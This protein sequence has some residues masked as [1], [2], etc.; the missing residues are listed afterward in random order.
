MYKPLMPMTGRQPKEQFI[1]TTPMRIGALEFGVMS[2]Q[3][4][5]EQANVEIY[6]HNLYDAAPGRVATRNGP[7]D[8]RLGAVNKTELCETC[9]LDQKHCNGHWGVIKLYYPCFHIGFLPFTVEILNKICKTCSRILLNEEQCR[10]LI[11]RL[12]RK[13]ELDD[14]QKKAVLREILNLCKKNSRCPWCDSSNGPVRRVPG[15]ACK[16]IH[17]QFEAY[18]KSTAQKKQPPPDKVRFD[19]DFQSLLEDS[20]ENEKHLHKAMDDMPAFKV[21]R[22]FQNISAQDYILLGIDWRKGRPESYLWTHIPVPPT[23]IRPSVPG[24]QGTTEDELT[25]K[26]TEIIEMNNAII[27]AHERNE[28]MGQWWEI[29][30]TLQDHL[31]MY[32]NSN[33]PGLQKTEYG[34]AI[35]SFCSRLKGKQGRFR[36]NLSGKRVNYSARTVISPDPNLSIE[37]VG[38]PIYVS[39]ILTYAEMANQNNLQRLR[40]MI[41][42]GPD[43]WPGAMQIKKRNGNTV[44][45]K[46]VQNFGKEHLVRMAKDLAIGDVVDRHLI[47]NDIVLF[48]RQP[49]LHKLSILAHMVKVVPGRTFRMNESVCNPYNADFDGDEMNIHVPQTEEARAEAIELMGVKHNLVT[50][51]DGTPIIGPIQDFITAAY[52]LSR[53]DVFLNR[54]QI[55]EL[56][57]HMFDSTTF[58]DPITGQMESFRLP[59]PTIWKPMRLWTGKQVFSSLMRPNPNCKVLVNLDAPC[60]MFKPDAELENCPE[61]NIDDEYVVIRNSEVLAGLMDKNIIGD[62]KKTNLFYVMLR[63]F[64]E[65]YAVMGMNRLAKLSSRWLGSQGFSIGLGDVYPSETLVF[66]KQRLMKEAYDK[67]QNI[68]QDYKDN[69]LRRDPGCDEEQTMENKVSGILSQ[70]RQDAGKVCMDTLSRHNAAVIMAKSGSKGSLINVSQMVAS[71]GQQMIGGKRVAEGFQDRTLPHFAKGS[72]EPA[73][74]GFVASSFFSGLNPTEFLFHAM[75]GREGLVDTAVKTAETGYMSRRLIK[76]LEDAHVAYDNTVRNSAGNIVNFTFGTDA[77]D[78]AMLEGKGRPVDFER[79]WVHTR[80]MSRLTN[81]AAEPLNVESAEKLVNLVFLQS[82]NKYTTHPLS[83][84][85][86]GATF[87]RENDILDVGVQNYPAARVFLK[88]LQAFVKNKLDDLIVLR[89]QHGLLYKPSTPAD[90][91]TYVKF[92]ANLGIDTL[93]NQQIIDN[94]M[95]LTDPGLRLFVNSCLEK[96]DRAIV[97]PGHAVGAIA[98]HS[99]GEPGTQMTLKTFHFA[100]VAGMS[101]T[102]G[103]P[104]IKE[105]INAAKKISTPVVTVELENKISVQAA[106]IVKARIERTYLKDIA[107]HI[108]DVWG[109]NGSWINIRFDVER[110]EALQLHLSLK[111]ICNAIIKTK[112]FKLKDHQVQI[113]GS[114][115]IQVKLDE[116][117]V[118]KGEELDMMEIEQP[119]GVAHEDVPLEIVDDLLDEDTAKGKGRKKKKSPIYFLMVQ[120]MRR[121][122]EDVLV[123][124]YPEALRAIV[125]KGERPNAAGLEEY[126]IMVEGY[127]LKS[128]M[129]TEGVNGYATKT[130]SVMEVLDVLGIEA[131]RSVIMSEIKEVMKSM[132]IDHRHISTL[133]DT[134][135]A[136]GE[137]LGITRFGMAKMRDSVLQLASFEK[138]PDH[139]FDAATRMKTDPIDGVSENIIMGQP[140]GLG[141]GS[142]QVMR[143][144]KLKWIPKLPTIEFGPEDKMSFMGRSADMART[145][146][147]IAADEEELA[148]QAS[149]CV[150]M[151]EATWE[152]SLGR[153]T[154]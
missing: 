26:L 27:A 40:D 139:L 79:T 104:R 36:G 127:G 126:K 59:P 90:A 142:V 143:P 56:L 54:C 107:E 66:E 93:Q 148:T 114:R 102:Q 32:I 13:P 105:I 44:S 11:A 75:S 133:A 14:F 110:M 78:P 33:A 122:L 41:E 140:V 119:N 136:K 85:V 113:Y 47:D 130:N 61:M 70:V 2:H 83:K 21:H 12:K 129:N 38:L 150:I 137:V 67:A 18:N 141:T 28:A 103:V 86:A 8:A 53:K 73:A 146:T 45:L 100:G 80:E 115:H 6:D 29:Y 69:K 98:A 87:T 34:K 112:G 154:N 58:K 94:I 4:M 134:M 117:E 71:V 7:L 30:E 81:P 153:K 60:K 92:L 19:D 22:I 106:Q 65:E 39:Q 5:E 135:T 124:G 72:R 35:R 49:S 64:G 88:E 52:L 24:E 97:Q 25:T 145:S 84:I 42:N 74:K 77:L 152:R 147:Q 89:S 99:I 108:E 95:T 82:Y 118:E 68:I 138:T 37:Q 55:G 101:I 1:D 46:V 116:P 149:G 31:A 111:D 20:P 43:Q 131:A 17:L 125:S 63:D 9:G 76:S 57:C 62:G 109:R 15:H 10:K 50:P 91:R 128:C 123:K 3:E 23:N 96:Y 51:K 121:S 120:E 132:D 48:N 16:L 151:D 144:L